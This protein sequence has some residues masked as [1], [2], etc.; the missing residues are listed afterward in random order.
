MAHPIDT[1]RRVLVCIWRS[2]AATV[3]SL[4]EPWA[5]YLE[6]RELR[7]A[8]DVLTIATKLGPQHGET[9]FAYERAGLL[10]RALKEILASLELELDQP[11]ARNTL[12]IIYAEM[13]DYDVLA[14][15]G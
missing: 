14:R 12:A 2:R 15:Y 11:D 13:D 5:V 10:P 8:I 7:T 4:P 9:H 1:G 3:G 6:R